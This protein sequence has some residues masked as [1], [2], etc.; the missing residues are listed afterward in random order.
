M[1]RD[2]EAIVSVSEANEDLTGA[3][4][5]EGKKSGAGIVNNDRPMYLPIDPGNGVS[6]EMSDD[7]KIDAAAAR[8]MKRYRRAFQELAK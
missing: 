2:R 5:E 6:G 3:A 4:R 8:I 7:E 1:T